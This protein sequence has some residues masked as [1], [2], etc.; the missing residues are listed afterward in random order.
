MTDY[1]TLLDV[2]EA[3]HTIGHSCADTL[4]PRQA[5]VVGWWNP[6]TGDRRTCPRLDGLRALR[7]ELTRLTT[8]PPA[9]DVVH[10]AAHD[11]RTAFIVGAASC[12]FTESEGE[13][14]SAEDRTGF[15]Q[16]GRFAIEALAE[17]LDPDLQ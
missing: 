1:A 6:N 5:T 11:D 9:H 13:Q 15:L 17:H 16:M 2:L 14:L 3:P 7:D 8:L 12:G 4:D 10:T